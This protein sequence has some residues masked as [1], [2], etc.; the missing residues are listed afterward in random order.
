M[1]SDHPLKLM[2]WLFFRL[3][4][5]SVKA[6]CTPYLVRVKKVIIE[7]NIEEILEDATEEDIEGCEIR[8]SVINLIDDIPSE[9]ELVEFF[10]EDIRIVTRAAWDDVKVEVVKNIPYDIDGLKYYLVKEENR[11]ELLKSCR[12]GRRWKRDSHTNWKGF[13]SVRYRN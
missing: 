9:H 2:E 8:D 6:D 13:T 3:S 7:N 11:K 12:D 10:K 1:K 5:S 4:N